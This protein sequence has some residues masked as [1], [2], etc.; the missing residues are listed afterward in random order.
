MKLLEKSILK[1]IWL[2]PLTMILCNRNIQDTP[3]FK[4]STSNLS[5]YKNKY[6]CN[7]I[8]FYKGA[9]LDYTPKGKCAGKKEYPDD[10][11]L[12]VTIDKKAAN[13]YYADKNFPGK[14]S[15]SV[16]REAIEIE[17][18]LPSPIWLVST[19]AYAAPG[20]EIELE[21]PEE[22]AKFPFTVQIGAH[23]DNVSHISG[24][25]RD[26]NV[27]EKKK[28]ENRITRLKNKRGGPVFIQLGLLKEGEQDFVPWW[29]VEKEIQEN[30]QSLKRD[31][32]KIQIRN[33][34]RAPRF[35][36]GKTNPQKW[37]DEERCNP[38]PWA[39]LESKY[40]TIA[41][42]SS[43]IRNLNNP[44]PVLNFWDSAIY[45]M[46]ELSGRTD[47]IHLLKERFVAD[48]NTGMSYMHSGY[49]IVTHMDVSRY[50][51]DQEPLDKSKPWSPENSTLME[52]YV[53]GHYHE[54]AH[55]RQTEDPW[56]T[57]GLT[58][59]SVNLF[60]MKANCE[61]RGHDFDKARFFGSTGIFQTIRYLA[62]DESMIDKEKINKWK[63]KFAGISNTA[64]PNLF[65]IHLYKHFGFDVYKKIITHYKKIGLENWDRDSHCKNKREVECNNNKLNSFALELSKITEKDMSDYL[66]SWGYELT[67]GAEEIKK[68]NLPKFEPMPLLA[69]FNTGSASITEGVFYDIGNFKSNGETTIN[70]SGR[71]SH[72]GAT[73]F[74]WGRE[75]NA[76]HTMFQ[77]KKSGNGILTYQ[78]VGK[79]SNRCLGLDKDEKKIVFRDCD[80]NIISQQWKVEEFKL[81]E[82]SF[83]TFYNLEKKK[84]LS[85]TSDK[86]EWGANLDFANKINKFN[87]SQLWILRDTQ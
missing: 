17:I 27:I 50:V 25:L 85:I 45:S 76:G 48:I 21:V 5:N 12:E 81:G 54:I 16:K 41:V 61:V 62:G 2:L 46:S 13:I 75:F 22:F 29:L 24:A 69:G 80:S 42:P 66:N 30:K 56:N 32:F 53:L 59:V 44:E 82:F 74:T 15:P 58:E 6:E 83:Y 71:A 60:L 43:A 31:S 86:P 63:N 57:A 72:E 14:I 84:Y 64:I 36:L 68:L 39:E 49:P 9:N 87:G 4:T 79:D 20:E 52:D 77:F 55:N 8:N 11:P 28:I 35:I 18:K 65:Y 1:L 78:L 10:I 47:T 19:G 23:S 51:V 7:K 37:V 33:V 26:S 70:V 40:L 73:V 38:A 34:I 67:W 3:K